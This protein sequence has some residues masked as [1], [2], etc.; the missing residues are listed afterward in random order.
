MKTIYLP[1][2]LFAI[3]LTSCV[4][5]FHTVDY[6]RYAERH[7]TLA[8]LP[9]EIHIVDRGKKDD[10]REDYE[11]MI[12]QESALFYNN[13]ADQIIKKSGSSKGDI[14]I[15]IQATTATMKALKTH[16]ISAVN[17]SDYSASELSEILNVDV[18][19]RPKLYTERFLSRTEAFVASTVLGI[20]KE[21]LGLPGVNRVKASEVKIIATIEDTENDAVVWRYDNTYEQDWTDEVDKDVSS[22]NRNIAK[23]FPYRKK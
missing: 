22:V 15:S 20:A 14:N 7:E 3:S 5:S 4:R 23:Y 9:F 1:I 16:G 19:L 11:T 18:V 10:S 2:L 21:G 6:D 17:I 8:V 13:L 12:K